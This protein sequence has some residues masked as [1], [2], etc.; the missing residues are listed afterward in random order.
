[1]QDAQS[2]YMIGLAFQLWQVVKELSLKKNLS[3]SFQTSTKQH[4]FILIFS[5]DR[6]IKLKGFIQINPD[7]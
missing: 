6:W 4:S 2:G 7:G 3:P 1:M 5:R